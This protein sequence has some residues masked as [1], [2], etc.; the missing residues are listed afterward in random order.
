MLTGRRHVQRATPINLEL[1]SL[2]SVRAGALGE[3]LGSDNFTFERDHELVNSVWDVVRK[4]NERCDCFKGFPLCHSL[5]DRKSSCMVTRL[6]SKVC[7]KYHDRIVA[8]FFIMTSP[9]V[10]ETVTE[11]HNAEHRSHQLSE[12]EDDCVLL[13]GFPP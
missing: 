11:A 7:E 5:V 3:L 4:E 10:S 9:K 6:I 12:N 1:G 2:E 13:E 8:T